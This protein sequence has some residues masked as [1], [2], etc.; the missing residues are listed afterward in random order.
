MSNVIV[1]TQGD[2]AAASV[3]LGYNT[4]NALNAL[5]GISVPE[6]SFQEPK[7]G[8]TAT[9]FPGENTWHSLYDHDY[10]ELANHIFSIG[11]MK[12]DQATKNYLTSR[13]KEVTIQSYEQASMG[14]FY[15]ILIVG[16][17]VLIV[18]LYL[19]SQNANMQVTVDGQTA[20]TPSKLPILEVGIVVGLLAAAAYLH[21]TIWARG[22]GEAY[23]Q[24]FSSDLNGKIMTGRL[25]GDILK[26]YG[27]NAERERDRLA[28]ARI[29]QSGVSGSAASGA[30]VGGLLAGMFR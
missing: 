6:Y 8:I 7:T 26:E 19:D 11:S 15:K 22:A 17:L 1:G 21:A 16:V 3:A 18:M 2:P 25:P 14:W 27:A 29:Q 13:V 5:S 4:Q 30:L 12:A 20:K 10:R 9:I 23:W 24:D 28:M